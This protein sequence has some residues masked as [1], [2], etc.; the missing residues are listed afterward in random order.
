MN[1]LYIQYL[2]SLPPGSNLLD[3]EHIKPIQG[4]S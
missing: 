1:I 4:D 2:E 3:K